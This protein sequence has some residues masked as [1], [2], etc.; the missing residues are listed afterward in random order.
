MQK[1]QSYNPVL[2]DTMIFMRRK[3]FVTCLVVMTALS[4]GILASQAATP[5]AIHKPDVVSYNPTADQYR[6]YH[7]V[8]EI[9]KDTYYEPTYSGQNW[10]RWEH[11]YDGKLKT[12]DD[13]KKGI[14][15]MLASLGDRYTRYLDKSAFE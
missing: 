8:W 14:E 9:I 11:H 15:T 2:P 13:A 10:S 12:M 6:L 5:T 3:L 4:G 7:R 1:F